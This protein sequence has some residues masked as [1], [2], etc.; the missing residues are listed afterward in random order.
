M[1][2]EILHW[3]VWGT[4]VNSLVL[5]LKTI[6]LFLPWNLIFWESY[7]SWQLSKFCKAHITFVKN[8]STIILC[9]INFR[10]TVNIFWK[11]YIYNKKD[12]KVGCQNLATKFGFVP[13]WLILHFSG[14]EPWPGSVQQAGD[15]EWN[16]CDTAIH[17]STCRCARRS[18]TRVSTGSSPAI[19]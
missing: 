18:E 15:S 11:H 19:S 14:V 4:S 2:C 13:D 6:N 7:Q 8:P 12:T 9:H 5:I 10:P 1:P 3:L 16:P 17:Q